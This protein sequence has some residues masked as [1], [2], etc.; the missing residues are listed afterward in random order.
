MN[1]RGHGIPFNGAARSSQRTARGRG[2][3]EIIERVSHRLAATWGEAMTPKKARNPSGTRDSDD[4]KRLVVYGS[5]DHEDPIVQMK[6]IKE[7]LD[8][9]FREE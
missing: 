4:S 7:A 9:Y 2:R 6:A 1:P 3:I 8:A 5:Y